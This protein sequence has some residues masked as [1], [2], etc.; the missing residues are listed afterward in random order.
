MPRWRDWWL[1][2]I[3]TDPEVAL[4]L[5]KAAV[6]VSEAPAFPAYMEPRIP[7]AKAGIPLWGAMFRV[8]ALPQGVPRLSGLGPFP[9]G[10]PLP[11][12]SGSKRPPLIPGVC[13]E[14][15]MWL[16]RS[17]RIVARICVT[18]ARMLV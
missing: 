11:G 5:R 6:Y 8:R 12:S 13:G 18:V 9:R 17:G 14:P 15:R 2:A 4:G 7:E 1:R 10:F 3:S 16:R